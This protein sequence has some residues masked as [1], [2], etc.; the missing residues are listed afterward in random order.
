EDVKTPRLEIKAHV[1]LGGVVKL[2]A[3]L[4]A[5]VDGDLL[6]FESQVPAQGEVDLI[7]PHGEHCVDVR[8]ARKRLLIEGLKSSERSRKSQVSAESRVLRRRA[9]QQQLYT[10]IG[11]Q[12]PKTQLVVGA[13]VAL[14]DSLII[15]IHGRCGDVGT[16]LFQNGFQPTIDPASSPTDRKAPIFGTEHRPLHEGSRIDQVDLHHPVVAAFAICR[17]AVVAITF[18]VRFTQR[19]IHDATAKATITHGEVPRVKIQLVQELCRDNTGEPTK[20]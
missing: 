8:L 14:H 16:G 11:S 18:R 1:Q 4:T 12:K 5:H 10:V 13:F 15:I 2:V 6:N 20:V 19:C 9:V 3:N 7:C 17:G